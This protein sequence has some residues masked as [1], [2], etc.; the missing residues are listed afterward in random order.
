MDAGREM[1]PTID[2]HFTP[3]CPVV[4]TCKNEAN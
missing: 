2:L 1:L 4:L 3:L